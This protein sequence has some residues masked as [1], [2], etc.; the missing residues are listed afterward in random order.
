[1]EKFIVGLFSDSCSY[2]YMNLLSIYRP[3]LL[4][5]GFLIVLVMSV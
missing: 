4:L 3:H 5:A 1:M 2:L